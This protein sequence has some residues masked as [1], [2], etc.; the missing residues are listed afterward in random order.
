MSENRFERRIQQINNA[1]WQP[2]E[3]Q[4]HVFMDDDNLEAIILFPHDK[5]SLRLFGL[6]GRSMSEEEREETCF[7]YN[8]RTFSGHAMLESLHDRQR[9]L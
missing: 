6:E 9:I 5:H 1:M 7:G 2:F 3:K 4:T 8:T